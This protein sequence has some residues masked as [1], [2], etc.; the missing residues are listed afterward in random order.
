MPSSSFVDWANKHAYN[1][2]F[3]L[4]IIASD[5]AEGALYWL[6]LFDVDVHALTIDIEKT[7]NKSFNLLFTEACL[8]ILSW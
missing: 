3:A 5:A 6:F 4:S 7:V 1:C 2:W 8:E